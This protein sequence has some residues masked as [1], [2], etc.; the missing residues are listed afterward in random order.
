MALACISSWSSEYGTR[1]PIAQ[2]AEV[3]NA[4][5]NQP[6]STL[7]F[8]TPFIDSFHAA[9]AA[10]F[11]SAARIIQPQIDAL[12]HLARHLDAVIFHED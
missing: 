12:H 3:S 11:F 5:S 1:S 4:S 10:R 2:P 6:S 8:N 7:K 9:R